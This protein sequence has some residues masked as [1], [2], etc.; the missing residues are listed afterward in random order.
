[1]KIFFKN[2]HFVQPTNHGGMSCI[3]H[4]AVL[5]KFFGRSQIGIKLQIMY[6]LL[7]SVTKV[8]CKGYFLIIT[9]NKIKH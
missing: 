6:F 8:I 5:L 1:M 9:M 4:F 7:F 2:G 3:T